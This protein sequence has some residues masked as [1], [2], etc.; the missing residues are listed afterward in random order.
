MQE[1]Y[2]PAGS[3]CSASVTVSLLMCRQGMREQHLAEQQWVDPDRTADCLRSE[4]SL[5]SCRQW[6]YPSELGCLEMICEETSSC[7]IPL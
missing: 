1:L 4:S 5:F 3:A 2:W 6:G 7:W